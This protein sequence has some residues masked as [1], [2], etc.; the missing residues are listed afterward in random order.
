M[1]RFEKIPAG[2]FKKA[3]SSD[4]GRL[5]A[6]QKAD[7]KPGDM[8][9]EKRGSKIV[10][11]KG[12]MPLWGGINRETPTGRAV[13]KFQ[14]WHNFLEI[15]KKVMPFLRILKESKENRGGFFMP[16]RKLEQKFPLFFIGQRKG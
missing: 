8:G 9:E 7:N 12:F 13:G 3:A 4:S 6:G 16:F 10:Q 2:R 15:L 14:E 1:S 5:Y 11:V